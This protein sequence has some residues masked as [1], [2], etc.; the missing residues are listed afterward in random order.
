M[1]ELLAVIHTELHQ[2]AICFGIPEIVRHFYFAVVVQLDR[3]I[4]V[5]PFLD[6]VD[7]IVRPVRSLTK[8][9]ILF[10]IYI[11]NFQCYFELSKLGKHQLQNG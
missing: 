8:I 9:C 4:Q 10:W 5:D 1:L 6:G 3:V 7:V 2:N 11:A